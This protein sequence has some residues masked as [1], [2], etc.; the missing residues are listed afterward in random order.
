MANQFQVIEKAE[1]KVNL[2]KIEMNMNHNQILHNG[3]ECFVCFR[4][5]T[6]RSP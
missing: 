4:K 2:H 1:D 5:Q 3:S 6:D